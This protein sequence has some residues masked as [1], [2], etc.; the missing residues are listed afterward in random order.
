MMALVFSVVGGTGGAWVGS[1]SRTAVLESNFASLKETVTS[2]GT[3]TRD[4]LGALTTLVN[5]TNQKTGEA[6]AANNKDIEGL[7]R[8][9]AALRT[10]MTRADDKAAEQTK[11]LELRIDNIKSAVDRIV[12]ELNAERKKKE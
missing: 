4:T 6:L 1:Q 8:E 12:G 2:Q 11:L 10:E 9:N 5:N 7:R 3:Q